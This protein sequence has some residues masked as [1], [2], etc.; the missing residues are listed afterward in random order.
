METRPISTGTTASVPKEKENGV[1]TIE[2]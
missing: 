1:S 2:V